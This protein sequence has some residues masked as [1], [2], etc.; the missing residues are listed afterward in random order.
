M[1]LPARFLLCTLLVSG[2]LASP[3]STD[4]SADDARPKSIWEARLDPDYFEYV[5]FS[6]FRLYYEGNRTAKS[7]E[8]PADMEY[9]SVRVGFYMPDSSEFPGAWPGATAEWSNGSKFMD[10]SLRRCCGTS[11]IPPKEGA[12]NFYGEFQGLGEVPD[13][14]RTLIVAGRNGGKGFFLEVAVEYATPVPYVG[15]PPYVERL[16]PDYFD[17]VEIDRFRADWPLAPAAQPA[18]VTRPFSSEYPY[19]LFAAEIYGTA[20][21]SAWIIPVQGTWPRLAIG[22]DHGKGRV[23]AAADYWTLYLP[24]G[25]LA[26]KGEG[27]LETPEEASELVVELE[28]FGLMHYADIVVYGATPVDPGIEP[29]APQPSE[30]SSRGG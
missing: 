14:N 22:F 26:G 3:A 10:V 5:E 20:V 9:V 1:R 27:L 12:V 21:S 11:N 29:E 6:S 30:R 8:L 16:D 24:P 13:G 7:V 28:G 15:V 17:R 19:T 4:G 23:Q 25:E 18:R 2:C